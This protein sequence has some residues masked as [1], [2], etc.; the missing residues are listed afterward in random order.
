MFDIGFAELLIIFVLGL[1]ILGPTRLPIAIKTISLWI[2]KLKSSYQVIKDEIESEL[3]DT[4]IQ[5]NIQKYKEHIDDTVDDI[6]STTD[7][8]TQ[9]QRTKPQ[10]KNTE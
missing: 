4:E 7:I 3:V 2:R 10:K 8:H 9:N 1:I 5:E 6:K